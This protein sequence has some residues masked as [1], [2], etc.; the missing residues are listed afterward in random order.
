MLFF[1]CSIFF[2]GILPLKTVF[3]VVK[4]FLNVLIM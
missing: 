1:Y 4:C 2:L 3:F